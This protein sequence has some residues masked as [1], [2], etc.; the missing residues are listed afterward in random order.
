MTA[1]RY[2]VVIAEDNRALGQVMKFNLERANFDVSLMCDGQQAADEIAAHGCD[3][4]ITDVEMPLMTGPQLC[5]Y[6][7]VELKLTDLP[8][9]VCSARGYELSVRDLIETYHLAGVFYKPMSPAAVVE[10]VRKQLQSQPVV[11]HS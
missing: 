7:R 9:A 4:L 6:V 11:C 1:L 2:K 10:F 3:L 8:I 5:Q